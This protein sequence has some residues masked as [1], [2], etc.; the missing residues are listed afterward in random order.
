EGVVQLL[1]LEGEPCAISYEA[2]QGK[3]QDQPEKVTIARI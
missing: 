3:Y 1:F 2:R